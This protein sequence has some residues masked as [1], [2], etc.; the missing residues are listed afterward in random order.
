M[1]QI[2]I[3]TF[4][5]R[6]QLGNKRFC[7]FALGFTLDISINIHAIYTPILV[8]PNNVERVLWV[9]RKCP[10]TILIATALRMVC[11]RRT[12]FDT[13]TDFLY[14]L[15]IKPYNY[16]KT[17]L[18]KRDISLCGFHVFPLPQGS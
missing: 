6:N 14:N 18:R 13:D 17:S 1:Y 5:K 9:K 10:S 11:V 15:T 16:T 2:N 7:N 8:F 12:P 4:I 3:I